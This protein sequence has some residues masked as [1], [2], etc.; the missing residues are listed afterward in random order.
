MSGTPVRQIS[1]I[2]HQSGVTPL[3]MVRAYARLLV[4]AAAALPDR[5]LVEIAAVLRDLIVEHA[6]PAPRSAA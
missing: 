1:L 6:P 4:D 5:D 3:G 2:C